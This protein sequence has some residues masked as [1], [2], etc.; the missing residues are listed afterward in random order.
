MTG[1]EQQG[2]SGLQV[3]MAEL[4]RYVE[5]KWVRAYE[6]PELP[7]L[8]CNYST[9]RNAQ[10]EDLPPLVRACRGLVINTDGGVVARSF[11]AMRELAPDE[12][13]P[14]G[15]FVAREK[16]DG[17]MVV[18]FPTN[19]GYQAATR[20]SF[21]GR[22]ARHA[23]V[24]LGTVDYDFEPELTYVWEMIWP[25]PASELVVDYGDRD[26][27]ILIGMIET[28][29][30]VEHP[31]PEPGT[32]PFSVVE[33]VPGVYS[34]ADLRALDTP[35]AEGF[36]VTMGDGEKIKVKFPAFEWLTAEKRGTITWQTWNAIRQRR[37]DST[38]LLADV[39]PSVH[40]MVGGYIERL[41][42]QREALVRRITDLAMS[43]TVG[44]VEPQLASQVNRMRRGEPIVLEKVWELL[45]P[46]RVDP[47][48]DP[49]RFR[50]ESQ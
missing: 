5:Q 40:D 7:L 43:S 12:E 48:Y 14:P 33:A 1:P 49:S 31:L 37:G 17:T 18:Q 45:R 42:H 19:E 46:P 22:H 35:N 50:R 20:R 9:P 38:A 34:A 30:G 16:L 2:F 41:E 44:E 11:S 28:A 13:L 27:L 47:N 25:D 21:K 6:H 32:V 15:D 3:D 8:V 10:L 36:V 23:N 24:L 4:S 26:E 39:P 29:T